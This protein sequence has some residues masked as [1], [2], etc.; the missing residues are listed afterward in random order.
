MGLAEDHLLLLLLLL[1]RPVQSAPSADTPLEC[2][3]D[4]RGE[5][6][7]A[8]AHPLEDCHGP[9]AGRGFEQRHHLGVEDRRQRIRAAPAARRLTR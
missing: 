5:I 2:P 6:G 9:E 1:L 4:T 7:M 3:P 8:P